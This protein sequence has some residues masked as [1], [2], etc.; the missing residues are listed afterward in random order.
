MNM[1]VLEKAE[2]A[3]SQVGE[4]GNA[5]SSIFLDFQP[6]R[7]REQAEK[8]DAR[9]RNGSPR[10]PLAGWLI[11]VKDLFN[12]AGLR[13]TAGSRLLADSAAADRDC[14]VVQRLRDAGAVIFGRT[15]MSEF[16]YSG[17][18]LNP[19]HGTPGNVFDSGHIPGGSSSGAALSVALGLCD[20]AIGTDTGGSVRIPAA[21]NGLVGFK[22][23]Q[24]TVPMAGVHPLSH[25]LDSVGPIARTFEEAMVV[26]SVLTGLSLELVHDDTKKLRIGL[27][28]GAFLNGLDAPT[29]RNWAL[30]LRKLARAGV[31]FEDIDLEFLNDAL[32][33]ARIIV[34][35]EAHAI[36]GAQVEKLELLGDPRVLRRIQYAE[37]LTKAEIDD[38]YA[39]R[40]E[41]VQKFD[42][43]LVNID[44]LVAPTLPTLPPRIEEVEADFDRLNASMLR[45]PSMIN[46]AD[47]CA[48]TMPMKDTQ[49]VFHGAAMFAAANGNDQSLLSAVSALQDYITGSQI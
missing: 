36:Y 35:V 12:E 8:V 49:S 39:K 30:L 41:V 38:A 29:E 19:H 37:T 6:E 21:A 4:L 14:I 15:S 47:G 46:I 10:L 34:A 26:Q 40:A 2:A 32:P 33:L 28:K 45:N 24:K 3:I 9:I 31:V 5:A 18:G 23:S 11:S 42:Q 16:A 22:P 17:V 48:I 20:A 1:T 7:I 43:A 27:P 13:T 44:A 25:T